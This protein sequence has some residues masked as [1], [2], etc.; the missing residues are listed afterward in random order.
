MFNI[1]AVQTPLGCNDGSMKSDSALLKWSE[2]L[3]EAST[4]LGR[5]LDS[6][7]LYGEQLKAAGYIDVEL[8]TMQWPMNQWP[9]DRKRKEIGIYWREKLV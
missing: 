3:L 7:R 9:R 2:L 6:A 5:K 1:D 8:H 4:K